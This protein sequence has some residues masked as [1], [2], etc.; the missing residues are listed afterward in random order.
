MPEF[1]YEHEGICQ[2]CAEGK[3][4]KGPFPSSVTKTTDILQFIHYDLSGMLPMT[5]LGGCYYYMMFIDEFSHNTQTYFLKKKKDEAF[6]WFHTF[7]ALVENQI[8][9]RIKVLS[10]DNGSEYE[11]HE[12]NDF[13]SEVGIKRETTILYTLEQNGVAERKNRTI[14]EVARTMLYD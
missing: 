5:S 12:F 4:T 14:V 11:S 2:G 1:K 8:E 10:T 7:K 13:F 6:K 3:H 9:K